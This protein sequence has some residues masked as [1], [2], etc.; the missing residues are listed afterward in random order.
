MIIRSYVFIKGRASFAFLR[1]CVCDGE[2]K[3]EEGREDKDGGD[4]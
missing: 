1:L 3:G 4:D 2:K